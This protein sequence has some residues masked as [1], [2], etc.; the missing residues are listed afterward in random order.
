MKHHRK[1]VSPPGLNRFIDEALSAFTDWFNSD[2]V[3]S[4]QQS[5][6][7][8]GIIGIIARVFLIGKVLHRV[9]RWLVVRA[10]ATTEMGF[11]C[12]VVELA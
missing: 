9:G 2:I 11:F 6:I 5:R 3:Q 1:T 7:N 10:T 8:I 4:D 12:R